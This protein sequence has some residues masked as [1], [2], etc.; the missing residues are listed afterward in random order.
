MIEWVRVKQ[1]LQYLRDKIIKPLYLYNGG[2]GQTSLVSYAYADYGGNNDE[3]K[4]TSGILIKYRDFM[5]HWRSKKQTSIATL[6][7]EAEIHSV[8]L[9]LMKALRIRDMVGQI[10]KLSD[11]L[12]VYYKQVCLANLNGAPYKPENRHLGS[13]LHWIRE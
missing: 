7:V 2:T 5:L 4:S 1:I 9:S 3:S 12:L 10:L 13:K 8:A 6:T 11:L